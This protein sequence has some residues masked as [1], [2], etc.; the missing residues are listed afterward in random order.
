MFDL[1]ATLGYLVVDCDG[2]RVGAV[3]CPM[4]ARGPDVPDAISVKAGFLSRHRRLVTADTIEVIDPVSR[5]I[6]LRVDRHAV[7][8]FL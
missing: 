4:F 1:T 2:H 8:A 5:V 7:R 6:G 3:E